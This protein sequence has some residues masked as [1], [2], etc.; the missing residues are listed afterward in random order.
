MANGMNAT[1]SRYFNPVGAHSPGA[2]GEAHDPETHDPETHDP[3]THL[4][5][6]ILNAI[7]SSGTALKVFDDDYETHDGT[8]VRDYVHVT[9][10]HRHIC[11][12]L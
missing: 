2:I 3:E 11:L 4:I 5:P 1:C 10:A 12:V 8:Y 7:I 6:N 9:F